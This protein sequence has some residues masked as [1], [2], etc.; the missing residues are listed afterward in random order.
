MQRQ[1]I[2]K[3]TICSLSRHSAKGWWAIMEKMATKGLILQWARLAKGTYLTTT[4]RIIQMEDK[5]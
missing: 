4:L 1:T 5:S 3:I 2:R